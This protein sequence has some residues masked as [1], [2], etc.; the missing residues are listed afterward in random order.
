[1][2]LRYSAGSKDGEVKFGWGVVSFSS[3]ERRELEGFVEVMVVM[4]VV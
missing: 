4:V 3:V 2:S 1:M